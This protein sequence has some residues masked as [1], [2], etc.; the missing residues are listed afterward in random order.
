VH[1]G[2]AAFLLASAQGV[3]GVLLRRLMRG[4]P[5]GSA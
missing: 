5:G 2:K 4:K 3:A 1:A